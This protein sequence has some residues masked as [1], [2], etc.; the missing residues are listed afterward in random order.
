MSRY[1]DDELIHSGVK[2]MK[3]RKHK[4]KAV[5]DKNGNPIYEN[6]IQYAILRKEWNY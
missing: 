6:T 3:W 5:R 1:F 2:G 4:Y